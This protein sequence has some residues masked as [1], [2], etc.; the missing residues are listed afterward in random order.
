MRKTIFVGILISLLTI[1]FISNVK[2]ITSLTYEYDANGNLI[3]GDGKYYEYNDANQLVRV[4]HGDQNGPVIAEY[5]Y[6]YTGQRIKKIE[7]GVTTYYVGKHYETQVAGESQT[8]TSYYFANGERVAK[9]NQSGNL[10][11][12]HSD[13]LGGTNVITDSIGDL[14]ERIKYYP[15]GEIREGEMK[16]ILLLARKKTN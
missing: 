1:V 5:F 13:H 10:Y 7:N 11:Y 9:K 14:I 2:A 12:Y 16:S 6:D 3:Q 15:F 8:N 4:R